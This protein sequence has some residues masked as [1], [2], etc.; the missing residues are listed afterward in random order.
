MYEKTIKQV[1]E[2][3]TY[4]YMAYHCIVDNS[5]DKHSKRETVS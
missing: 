5:L 3:T 2:I 1:I 4:T